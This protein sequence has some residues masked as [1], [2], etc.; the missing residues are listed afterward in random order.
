MGKNDR[1][2]I[3]SDSDNQTIKRLPLISKNF[4]RTISYLTPGVK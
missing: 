1:I 3:D 4:N 2:N